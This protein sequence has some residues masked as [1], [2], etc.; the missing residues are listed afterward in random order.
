MAISPSSRRLGTIA[1]LV[2]A[3]GSLLIVSPARAGS[4]GTAGGASG[5]NPVGTSATTPLGTANF[6]STNLSQITVSVSTFS[7]ADLAQALVD[8]GLSAAAADGVLALL[9][10]QEVAGI[11]PEQGAEAFV[12]A[13]AADG[14]PQSQ[15]TALADALGVLGASPNLQSLNNAIEAYNALVN[16]TDSAALPALAGEL[17][18]L[19][20]FFTTLIANVST[21]GS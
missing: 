11:S 18:P 19:R 10:N 8:G 3:A 4:D 6:G 20:A 12:A 9:T 17:T 2:V 15:A 1:A 5:F 14:A 21:T 16:A 7:T 13:L